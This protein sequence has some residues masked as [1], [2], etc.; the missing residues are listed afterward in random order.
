MI[1]E[2]YE[3]FLLEI[4]KKNKDKKN[5]ELKEYGFSQIVCQDWEFNTAP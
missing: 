3:N 4:E 1:K 5:K 2:K